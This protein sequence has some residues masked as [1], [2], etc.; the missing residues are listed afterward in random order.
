M[1]ENNR[2][3][4]PVSQEEFEAMRQR[5]ARELLA[6]R[7]SVDAMLDRD[8]MAAEEPERRRME[9]EPVQREQPAD[10][11]Q[12][13]PSVDCQG[14][15]VTSRETGESPETEASQKTVPSREEAYL[16]ESAP[17]QTPGLPGNGV[18]YPDGV[19]EKDMTY[20]KLD[21]SGEYDAD[22]GE[23]PP[24]GIEELSP[25]GGTLPPLT[26]TATIQVMVSAAQ[27][28]VPIEGAAVLVSQ[29]S[30][31]GDWELLQAM[32][33]DF[34]G[35]TPIL[36]VP[37]PSRE[38]T[39]EPGTVL[40]FTSYQVAVTAEG[41]FPQT[42]SNV[43]VFG[44]MSSLLSVALVPLLQPLVPPPNSGGADGSLIF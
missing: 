21:G 40:P 5:Y 6:I 32:R 24:E 20:H 8:L 15:P 22:N 28:A 17:S 27:Q 25:P 14:N 2:G 12:Q 9:E 26:D 41:Y 35:K 44:G 42:N 7:R 4:S 18:P 36:T 13:R 43:T 1:E 38:L 16:P 29:K 23:L 11:A 30:K 10:T 37:A 3:M 34:S 39:Q 19:Y 31:D 33:T